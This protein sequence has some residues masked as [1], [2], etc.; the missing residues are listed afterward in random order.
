MQVEYECEC[1]GPCVCGSRSQV[2]IDA[3]GA[4][5]MVAAGPIPFSDVG[6]LPTPDDN[7]AIAGRRV[8]AGSQMLF[9][10]SKTGESYVITLE[11]TVLE[12]HRCK[13]YCQRCA[14]P[15]RRA[16][17]FCLFLW[18]SRNQRCYKSVMMFDCRV[19]ALFYLPG[20]LFGRS[21]WVSLCYPGAFP[22]VKPHCPFY[23]ANTAAI[24][25]LLNL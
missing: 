23:L 12:G 7:V 8:E 17:C 4:S 5:P 3:A 9:H 6:R 25:V 1:V 20:L 10:D 13:S 2:T 18:D 22:L 14:L 24:S 15:F 21:Q 11:H 19:D 16:A